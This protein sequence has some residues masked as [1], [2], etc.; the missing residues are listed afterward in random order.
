[1]AAYHPI[2]FRAAP[3]CFFL[4]QELINAMLFDKLKVLYHAQMVF[5]AIAFIKVFQPATGKTLAFIAE[6]QKSFPQ[7]ITLTCHMGTV[8][9]AW[10]T[11]NAVLS[12]KSLLLEVIFHRQVADTKVAVHSTWGNKF[13]FHIL[14]NLY[15]IS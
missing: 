11:A 14:K 12:R 8:L 7:Q 3:L 4:F 1:M 13:F 15:K 10:Q 9:T 2:T 5:C 6:A